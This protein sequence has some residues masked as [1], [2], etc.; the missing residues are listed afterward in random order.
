MLAPQPLSQQ[1]D[2][3]QYQRVSGNTSDESA[4]QIWGIRLDCPMNPDDAV[5]QSQAQLFSLM[6]IPNLPTFTAAGRD[7]YNYV[8]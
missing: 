1:V 3:Q 6:K 7:G 8:S 4:A 5:L 2:L